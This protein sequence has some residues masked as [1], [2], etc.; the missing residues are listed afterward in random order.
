[1]DKKTMTGINISNNTSKDNVVLRFDMKEDNTIRNIARQGYEVS[2]ILKEAGL[3]FKKV[4]PVATDLSAQKLF[5]VSNNTDHLC[6]D[7]SLNNLSADQKDDV[8]NNIKD[9]FLIMPEIQLI[10]EKPY[11]Y[12]SSDNAYR[13]LFKYNQSLSK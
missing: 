4:I 6:L 5:R 3:K 2:K 11:M 13:F 8:I 12:S 10:D 9:Q 7:V 1:M